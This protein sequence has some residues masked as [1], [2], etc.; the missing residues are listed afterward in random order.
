MVEGLMGTSLTDTRAVVVHGAGSRW[1]ARTTY[2]ELVARGQAT[3][4]LEPLPHE[5][6]PRHRQALTIIVP[7]RWLDAD[8]WLLGDR[9]LIET[10]SFCL[11]SCGFNVDFSPAAMALALDHELR[12][13]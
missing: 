2:H 5:V 13:R 1:Y 8:L 10:K 9:P 4:F 6:P 12:R 7:W 11:G 3:L